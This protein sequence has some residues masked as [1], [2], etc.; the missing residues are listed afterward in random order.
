MES[1][2]DSP[3]VVL[4]LRQRRDAIKL[5]S[6]S[7]CVA[8]IL[9]LANLLSSNTAQAMSSSD[10]NA[11]LQGAIELTGKQLRLSYQFHNATDSDI[12][13]FNLLYDDLDANGRYKVDHNLCNIELHESGILISKK[14]VPVPELMF[15]ETPNIPCV[16]RIRPRTSFSES[17]TLALPLRPWSPYRSSNGLAKTR[18]LPCAFEIGYFVAHPDSLRLG[19]TVSTTIGPAL[20]FSP[21]STASQRLLRT[22]RFPAVPAYTE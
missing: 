3:A 18:D 4:T 20:R 1:Q 9:P 7:A 12:L 14:I 6:T 8:A 5:L 11:T 16:T 22:D 2:A 15:V 19:V 17:V 10:K 21:F 13:L